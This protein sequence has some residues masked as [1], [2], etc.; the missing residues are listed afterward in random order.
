MRPRCLWESTSD[1]RWLVNWRSEKYSAIHSTTHLIFVCFLINFR[2]H[3]FETQWF[4][5]LW[6]SFKQDLHWASS[7]YKNRNIVN[8]LMFADQMFNTGV[9]NKSGSTKLLIKYHKTDIATTIQSQNLKI[10]T[11][12]LFVL[13]VCNRCPKLNHILFPHMQVHLSR[14]KTTYISLINFEKL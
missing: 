8:Q 13:E 3:C 5:K 12:L 9:E 11:P 10:K 2:H 6:Y 1:S 4:R 7:P 14:L